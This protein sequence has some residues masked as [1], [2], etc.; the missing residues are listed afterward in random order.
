MEAIHNKLN[1]IQIAEDVD[2]NEINEAKKDGTIWYNLIFEKIK[3]NEE[4]FKAYNKIPLNY[5]PKVMKIF[6]E[7]LPKLEYIQ[8]YEKHF[9]QKIELVYNEN[10]K[11]LTGNFNALA[12]TNEDTWEEIDE[13]EEINA[14]KEKQLLGNLLEDGI[15]SKIL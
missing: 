8:D 7:D 11:K 1:G 5:Q 2:K 13:E 3:Q 6:I 15:L 4:W 10:I 12:G 14:D 9:E